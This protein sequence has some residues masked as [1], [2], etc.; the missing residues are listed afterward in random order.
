MSR[1]II[2]YLYI[3]VPKENRGNLREH[4]ENTQR[5]SNQDWREPSLIEASGQVLNYLYIIILSGEAFTFREYPFSVIVINK[6]HNY[7]KGTI[8]TE[9]RENR[10]RQFKLFYQ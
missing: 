3:R 6:A 7:I 2:Q 10:P 1:D 9:P 8:G 5:T 4:S